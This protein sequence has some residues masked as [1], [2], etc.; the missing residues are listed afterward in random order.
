MNRLLSLLPEGPILTDGAWGTELQKL[1][2]APGQCSDIW[3]LSHPDAVR[4]VARSYVEAGSQI[5]LTNT[6]QSSRPALDRV[7]ASA[8]WREINRSAVEHSRKEAGSARLVFGS[9]GPCGL[10]RD[11]EP[12]ALSIAYHEQA[13]LLAECGADALVLETFCDSRDALIASRA[14]RLIGL[15]L[16]LSFAALEQL[17]DDSNLSAMVR[18]AI[19][20]EVDAVGLNCGVSLT[21][22]IG[23]LDRLGRLT[24]LPIW[25]KPTAGY[26]D[27]V[28]PEPFASEILAATPSLPK[29]LGGCCGAGP[30]HIACL[31]S[32][33]SSATA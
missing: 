24:T 9:I 20:A 31:A 8:S 28:A 27:V 25:F 4:S 19:E 10:S 23:L 17:A 18:V 12:T 26:P 13:A 6:F 15:P 29:I 32:G 14:C 11:I 3:N 33:L 16:V 2:L 5:L 7:G 21:G 30:V 1:G 22:A